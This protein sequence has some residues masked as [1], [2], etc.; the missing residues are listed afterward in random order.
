MNQFTLQ[1]LTFVCILFTH[2]VAD[3]LFQ[4]DAE[5]K[6]KSS[7]NK[8]LLRHTIKYTIITSFLWFA[9]IP[10]YF[11]I[12]NPFK[13]IDGHVNIILFALITFVLHTITDYFT[14]RLN[15]KLWAKGDVHGFF[16]SVGF[17]Q[18]LHFV[19]LF[20]TYYFLIK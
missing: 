5:A 14:S 12:L 2:W 1:T 17:D 9:L 6:G 8:M 4:N 13:S 20:L 16:V 18:F 3:F 7:S 15:S 10:C 19:Q 11:N